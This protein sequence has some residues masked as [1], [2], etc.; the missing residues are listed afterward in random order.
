MRQVPQNTIIWNPFSVEPLT[1][2]GVLRGAFYAFCFLFFVFYFYLEFNN[3]LDF[4][5]SSKILLKHQTPLKHTK[6]KR[7][8]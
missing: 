8:S 5:C 1:T 7:S 4:T 2:T 6:G 3:G